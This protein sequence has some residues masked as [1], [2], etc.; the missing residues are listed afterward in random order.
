MACCTVPEH[1]VVAKQSKGYFHAEI[2]ELTAFRFF[3]AIVCFGCE[4]RFSI[5]FTTIFTAI[6]LLIF[7]PLVYEQ[8]LEEGFF[9]AEQVCLTLVVLFLT[10]AFWVLLNLHARLRH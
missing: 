3:M 1:L 9:V 10:T 5:A 4:S 2:A 7:L 6:S 8:R